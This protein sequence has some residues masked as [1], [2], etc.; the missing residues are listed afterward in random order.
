MILELPFNLCSSPMRLKSLLFDV[1]TAVV[2]FDE[3]VE[4]G[5]SVI[6][7]FGVV[8]SGEEIFLV[9]LVGSGSG[10]GADG[11]D[12]QPRRGTM[13]SAARHRRQG[14]RRIALLWG[15]GWGTYIELEKNGS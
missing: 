2:F 14:R 15:R 6:V 7:G 1:E 4:V 5:S 3:R 11:D 10:S 9:R 8:G 13:A 12:E